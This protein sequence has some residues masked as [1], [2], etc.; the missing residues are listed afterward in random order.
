M[1]MYV[2]VV[3]YVFGTVFGKETTSSETLNTEMCLQ[4]KINAQICYVY[5]NIMALCHVEMSYNL[6]NAFPCKFQM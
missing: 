6:Q 5:G 1:E 2:F 3:V 4:S